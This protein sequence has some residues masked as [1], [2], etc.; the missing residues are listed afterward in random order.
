V[1][2]SSTILNNPNYE[3]IELEE[4]EVED[5]LMEPVDEQVEKYKK[6]EQ[7]LDSDNE[8]I[9]NEDTIYKNGN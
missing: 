7:M 2:V 3:R 9:N 8:G 4:G 1:K 5:M 6:D